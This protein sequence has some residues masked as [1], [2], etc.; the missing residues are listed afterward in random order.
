[1]RITDKNFF[2]NDAKSLA[3]LLLGKYLCRQINNDVI[4]LKI[5][6]VEAYTGE[7]DTACHSSIG[8]TSRTNTMWEEGGILYVC[9]CYGIH[10]MLNIVCAGKDNPQTVL[11]RG[12]EGFEGPGKLTK[13]LQIDKTFNCE[14]ITI[15]ERI[16]IEDGENITNFKRSPRIG[17]NYASDADRVALLRFY[18]D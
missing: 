2:N 8:R 11:I 9:L 7:K 6:E 15:S 4:K 14:D 12:V 1:M 10:S 5:I 13:H 16:W 18:I 3:P 17:I